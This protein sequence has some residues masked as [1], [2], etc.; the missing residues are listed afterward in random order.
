MDRRINKTK[1]SIKRA[2]AYLLSQ[3]DVN[4]ITITDIA[5]EADINRKTFYNYYGGIYDVI[6]EI[7]N[8]I[9]D[10]FDETSKNLHMNDFLENPNK[11]L[12]KLDEIVN[13][14]LEYYGNLIRVKGNSNL[15][16]K[17]VEIIK[18]RVEKDFLKEYP[19]K[20]PEKVSFV[21]DFIF[22]GLV[23]TFRI[24]FNA[25]RKLPL[26]ELSE[27]IETVIFTG[28]KGMLK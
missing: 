24:W 7:E 3:K 5:N 18:E 9:A 16:I 6:D 27:T 14:D 12:H 23:E 26:S 1:K 4:D 22:S 17:I 11:V 2:F 15:T 21:V 10:I 28:I 20:D 19:G 8:E 25:D 13:R